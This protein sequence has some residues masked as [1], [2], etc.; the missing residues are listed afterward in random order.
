MLNLIALLFTP[1]PFY[2]KLRGV[3][4]VTDN[5]GTRRVSFEGLGPSK[6][7]DAYINQKA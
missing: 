7:F 2:F 6:N 3:D 5:S 1:K 4:V